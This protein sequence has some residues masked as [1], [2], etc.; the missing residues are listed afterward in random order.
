M[1]QFDGILSSPTRQLRYYL[2]V[3][4]YTE[5]DNTYSLTEKKIPFSSS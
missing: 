4:W 1:L 5:I 2:I 3:S